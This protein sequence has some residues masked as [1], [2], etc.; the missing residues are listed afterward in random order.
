MAPQSPIVTYPKIVEPWRVPLVSPMTG[1]NLIS[2]FGSL[3][4]TAD[5]SNTIRIKP[6][7][8]VPRSNQPVRAHLERD[9]LLQNK[10]LSLEMPPGPMAAKYEYIR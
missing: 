3:G 10:F 1:I 8:D 9:Q 6:L 5:G 4:G 7:R 2:L